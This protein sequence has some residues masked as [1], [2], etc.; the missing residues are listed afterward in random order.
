[1]LGCGNASKRLAF[2]FGFLVLVLLATAPTKA[3]APLSDEQIGEIAQQGVVYGLPLILM[4][5]TRQVRTNAVEPGPYLAPV[6]Q[7]AQNSEYHDASYK[8]VV[9]SNVDS[10]YTM[11]W[12]DLREEPVVLSVPDTH[13]RFYLFQM[14]DMWTDVFASPG[15]RTTGSDAASFAIVG[16]DWN[17]TLPAT[18][19][20]IR[21]PTNDVWLIAPTQTNGPADYAAVHAIQKQYRLAPLSSLG[22]PYSPPRGVL[23]QTVDMQTPPVQQ[24][25]KLGGIAFLSRLALLMTSNRPRPDDAPMLARLAR[26]GFV[27]GQPFVARELSAA[28]KARVEGA[29]TAAL[30]RLMAPGVNAHLVNGWSIPP[31]ILGN[32]GTNYAVRAQ[33]ALVGLAANLPADTI[34]P[35]AYVDAEGEGLSGAKRYLLHFEKDKLPPANAFWSVTMYTPDSFF[36][37]NAIDRYALSSWMPL[38]FEADG[39]LDLYL[40]KDPPSAARQ[41]NWLPAPEG[42]FNVTMRLYWPKPEALDG[43]W[44]PPGIREIR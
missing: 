7:F 11:A 19:R 31:A 35:T 36:V 23:D 16:P 30:A 37:P 24:V 3:Q 13:G 22:R 21:A 8:L 18:L 17:G 33:V 25:A 12:L 42:P 14:L 4:D 29:V 38:K 39:S 20:E 34:Y 9:R 40:Q 28:A 6:N 10:L 32:F 41:Q 2:C 27:P 1:M 5:L 15:T 43:R 26:I 44:V